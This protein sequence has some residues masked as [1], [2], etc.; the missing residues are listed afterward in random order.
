MTHLPLALL[1]LATTATMAPEA[2][3]PA[4]ER[5]IDLL[6]IDFAVLSSDGAPIRDLAA[7]EITVRVG[8]RARAVRSLQLVTASAASVP[9]DALS[10]PIDPPFSSNAVGAAGRTIV[11]ALDEDSYRPGREGML[12]QSVDTLIAGLAPSDRLALVTMPLGGLRVP[13]T[14]DHARVR[15]A[16][17]GLAGRGLSGETGSDAACRTRIT[18]EAL[19]SFL[20]TLGYRETPA[21]L[22]FVTGGLAAPR[23]DAPVSMAPGRC[24]LAADLYRRVSE[25][26]GAARAQFYVVQIGDIISTGGIQTETIAGGGYRG[27]DNAL[28][29][30]EHLAGVTGGQLLHLTG[31]DGGAMERVL[32]ETAAY[33]LAAVEPHAS[34]RSGRAQPLDV[35]V[36]RAGAHLRA[37]PEIAFPAPDPSSRRPSNPS[38]RE[39]IGA[40]EEFSDL[41]LRASAFASLDADG[42]RLRITTL[43]E[44][45][46]PAAKLTSLVAALFT[47]EGTLIANWVATPAE[48]QQNPVVGAMHAEPGAYR[49][50]VAAIDADGRSGTTDYALDAG[51]VQT[52]ALKLSSLVLGR[53]RNGVF[54]PRLEFTTEPA[55]AV[56][57]EMYGAAPGA[58]VTAAVEISRS[59]NGPAVLTMPLAIAPAGEHRYVA[60]AAIPI[61]ALPPGDYAVRAV[62]GLE[63]QPPTRIARTLRKR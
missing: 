20:G 51:L 11:L 43:A 15:N 48:L 9:Q 50:R 26:A 14:T 24:E 22:L 18:L 59:A 13:L 8:G 4:P 35:R 29:G 40:L 52:G 42:T 34:D 61:G 32:R 7:S 23:R 55:A 49:M 33:Y 31:P 37:R 44:P 57:V 1:L 54:T 63:G 25:I 12:R 10:S 46:D 27:S 45:L 56:Y 41:P 38:P 28:E 36:T 5:G 58:R 53:T 16:L 30:L 19:S 60:K 6:K 62:I 3:R 17:S 21:T 39:M 2:Q 47:R